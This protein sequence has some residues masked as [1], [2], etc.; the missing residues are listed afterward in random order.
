MI[1]LAQWKPLLAH[2][3]NID[4]SVLDVHVESK[5]EPK[6]RAY[7]KLID[8]NSDEVRL[9][10]IFEYCFSLCNLMINLL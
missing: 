2:L 6:C 9:C 10:F 5:P 3:I 4:D 7:L 8:A 1:F